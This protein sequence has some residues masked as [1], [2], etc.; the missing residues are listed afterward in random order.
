MNKVVIIT[1]LLAILAFQNVELRVHNRLAPEVPKQVGLGKWKYPIQIL[2]AMSIEFLKQM[3]HLIFGESFKTQHKRLLWIFHAYCT[4]SPKISSVVSAK[5][6][7]SEETR[8][9]QEYPELLRFASIIRVFG[10][11]FHHPILSNQ[12]DLQLFGFWWI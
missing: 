12:L 11:T 9:L 4:V 8:E 5:K 6:R 10:N 7:A 1:C 2:F 3:C